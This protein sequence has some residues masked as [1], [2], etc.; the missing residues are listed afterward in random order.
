[1]SSVEILPAEDADMRRIFECAAKAFARNEPFFDL[2]YPQHWTEQGVETGGERMTKIKN[3]DPNTIFLKAVDPKTGEIMGMAKWNV[4]GN[5]DTLPD[6]S[7]V[8]DMGDY[9][10]TAEEKRYATEAVNTFLEDRY[11]A[12]KTRHG[13]LVSLD[14]LAIDPAYQR[15][16][17]GGALVRWGTDKAD[18]LGVETVVESSVFGKGLYEKHG[19]E[20]VKQ[21]DL[22][23]WRT[24][25]VASYAWLI[26]P[27][28][29]RSGV[30]S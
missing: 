19:F 8:T 16:G 15:R 26:R 21:Q 12:I 27:K 1:M 13:N 11:D 17:V 25:P 5:T 10:P 30:S 28:K 20:F 22:R 4:Y 7:P 9:W 6:L 14:I 23:G 3:S 2:V 29:A 24:Q 18:E